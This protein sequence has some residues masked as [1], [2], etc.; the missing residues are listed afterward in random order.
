MGK[1]SKGEEDVGRTDTKRITL[2]NDSFPI[3]SGRIAGY[4]IQEK[5]I[6]CFRRGLDLMGRV[7]DRAMFLSEYITSLKFPSTQGDSQNK[8]M[9]QI[10]Y[11][12]FI[13]TMAELIQKYRDI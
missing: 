5:D 9:L 11:D 6:I 8:R 10:N 4:A 7:V 1:T 2:N 12:T 13:N 3:F